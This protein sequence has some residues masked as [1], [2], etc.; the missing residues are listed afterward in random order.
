MTM[1]R[2]V[3]RLRPLSVARML[4]LLILLGL[5]AFAPVHAQDTSGDKAAFVSESGFLNFS[6]PADWR[7]S[8]NDDG[9]V[10]VTNTEITMEALAAGQLQSGDISLSLVL[11]PSALLDAF[12][13][14]VMT[15]DDALQVIANIPVHQ[16]AEPDSTEIGEITAVA[17]ES[18]Y[19]ASQFSLSNGSLDGRVIAV[20][21]TDG[22]IVYATII[23][24]VG[25]YANAEELIQSMLDTLDYSGTAD[26]LWD[27]LIGFPLPV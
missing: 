25:E 27:E 2:S 15:S 19:E 7:L 1:L 3:R 12:G 10:F 5:A 6:Y 13:F 17:L 18:G 8:V 24:P 16:L 23:T 9:I 14:S 11:T 4:L 26:D 20:I 21:P 22:V